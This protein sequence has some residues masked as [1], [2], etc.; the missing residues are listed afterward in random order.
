MESLKIDLCT[1]APDSHLLL[2][3]AYRMSLKP[4]V[5]TTWTCGMDQRSAGLFL[6][7]ISLFGYYN[8]D[9]WSYQ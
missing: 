7:Y 3:N 8:F 5:D 6:S 2:A 4:G 1:V 9:N